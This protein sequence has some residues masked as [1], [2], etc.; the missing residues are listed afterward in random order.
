MIEL[1]YHQKDAVNAFFNYTLEN[2]NKNPLIVVPTG[3]GKGLIMAAIV[4]RML[5]FEN[6]R[7]LLLAH[8]STLLQ[9]TYIEITNLL[10]DSLSLFND[11][12]I[13]SA[14]LNLRNTRNRVLLGGI[15]SV[16]NK[17]WELGYFDLILID[18]VQRCPTEREGTYR[19]FLDDMRKINPKII[20]GGLSATCYRM[21]KGLLCDPAHKDRIFHDICYEATIPELMDANH[22]KNKDR[23]Q[24]LCKIISKNSL[25]SADLSKVH[26]KGGEYVQNEME[27][28][29]NQGDLIDR[30]V[31]EIILLTEIRKKIIIFCA[32][33]KHCKSVYDCLTYYGMKADFAHSKRSKEENEKAISDFKSGKIKYLLN[34]DK[35]TEGFDEKAI[36]CIC[37]LRSTMSPGLYSQ[38]VGRVLR[39]HPN[40]NDGLVLDMGRN[41]ETHGPIDKIEIR[42]NKEGKS[43]VY[44][45]PMK[46]CPNCNTALPISTRICPECGEVLVDDTPKHDDKASE[47]D[48]ISKWKKPEEYIVTHANFFKHDKQGSPSSMRVDYYN[49]YDKIVSEWVCILHPG[50]A[51]K[52]A[53]KWLRDRSNIAPEQIENIE[54]LIKL[55]EKIRVPEKIFIDYNDKFPKIV[56]YVFPVLTE[57]EKEKLKITE[58]PKNIEPE[59]SSI[60]SF[61]DCEIPF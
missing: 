7:V 14:S 29:F 56:K 25:N 61:D 47:K 17:A 35:F 22:Y 54:D 50:Y 9:Q 49:D 30:T 33:I 40:K 16:H 42:K 36:D 37:L 39:I 41:I 5:E 13:Y 8:R 2:P 11:I 26:I 53:Y 21:G 18:E 1:R 57:Q 46:T 51:G 15:Q 20:I 27:Q 23:K 59:W 45:Q 48:I 4:H 19:R 28:A 6:T 31:K 43:E 38:M 24:Y 52:K 58:M 12:G 44:T 34:I 32:G 3:G 55:K 60:P 10:E